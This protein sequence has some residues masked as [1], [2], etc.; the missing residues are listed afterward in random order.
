M[1][2]Y[3]LPD[4]VQD[5]RLNPEKSH[6]SYLYDDSSDRKILDMFGFFSTLPLGYN[7]STFKRQEYIDDVLSFGGIKP[8]TGRISSRYVDEFTDKFHRFANSKINIFEKYFL[9]HG[10]GLAVENALKISFDWKKIITRNNDRNEEDLEVIS[11]HEGFHGVT[12]Y[13][14]SLSDNDLKT[15]GFPKFNWPKFDAPAI[16][17]SNPENPASAVRTEEDRSLNNI[18]NYIRERGSNKIASI[19]IELIQ[20][21]GGDR[22]ISSYFILE[23]RK[24]C[25]ENDILFIVDEVQ[26][27]FGVTGSVWYF[28]QIGVTPD[29]IT[30][31]KKAQISGVCINDKLIGM[32]EA[33]NVPG[34]LSPTWNGNIDDY[35]RCYH[36]INAYDEFGLISNAKIQGENILSELKRIELFNN[37]R[38]KGFL[39]AFDFSDEETRNKFNQY[40]FDKGLLLLPM[41]D[42]TLRLRPN[43]AVTDDEIQQCLS[44][45]NDVSKII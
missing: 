26:T 39:I 21:G 15:Q 32:N 36:I 24:I 42:K 9:I 5:L 25:T 28:E 37:V 31:G 34:R 23:L 3:F 35:I 4:W 18:R 6:G 44:I 12:G 20:G 33:L 11:F 40:C 41:K 1:S 22:H 29:L 10:G 14:I 27:G 45:I 30:F 2:K 8:S 16:S 43:M 38:G 7:H 19:I 13:T 17:F